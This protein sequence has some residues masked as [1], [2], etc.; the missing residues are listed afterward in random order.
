MHLLVRDIHL[1]PVRDTE[2]RRGDVLG[3]ALILGSN[4]AAL[5]GFQRA[6][7]PSATAGTGSQQMSQEGRGVA[8]RRRKHF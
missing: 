7:D 4:T 8:G 1:D 3:S 2:P 5:P 6:C